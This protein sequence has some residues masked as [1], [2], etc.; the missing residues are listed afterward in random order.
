[1]SH[2]LPKLFRWVFT[3]LAVLTALA[4][5]VLIAVILVDPTLPPDARFGPVHGQLMGQPATL[6]LQP[7]ASSQGG[8]ALGQKLQW[9][10]GVAKGKLAI[11]ID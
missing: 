3:G 6:A 9:Q 7:D 4:A 2:F 5:V 8:P 11:L 1:M 10:H